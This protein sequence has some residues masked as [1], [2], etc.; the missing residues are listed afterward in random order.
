M[1]AGCGF[2]TGRDIGGLKGLT[3][4]LS[5]PTSVFMPFGENAMKLRSMS[6]KTPDTLGNLFWQVWRDEENI[7]SS[8]ARVV[9]F[10][11]TTVCDGCV[12]SPEELHK[13][14]TWLYPRT[15]RGT[16]VSTFASL[17]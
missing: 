8:Q 11:F 15:L 16:R 9:V 10:A 5:C 7:N 2:T 3:S 12:F 1:A 6:V 14:L 13:F 4:C 17:G